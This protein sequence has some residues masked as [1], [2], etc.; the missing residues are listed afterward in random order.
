MNR[1]TIFL[2]LMVGLA[3]CLVAQTQLQRK[4]LSSGA[5]RA[6]SS[7]GQ[8]YGSLGQT[9]VG[10]TKSSAELAKGFW[11]R[12]P[13]ASA[14]VVVPSGE[15]EIGTTITVPVI[16][17]AS[18]NL[19][20]AGALRDVVVTLRYNR[21]VLVSK[22]I[23][24]VRFDGDDAL[25]TIAT[26]VKDTIGII[27]EIP[28]L[29]ALGNAEKTAVHIESVEWPASPFIRTSRTDGE[30]TVLGIC[31]E[32][33]TV[34][35]IKRGSGTGIVG[36]VPMPVTTQ[37]TITFSAGHEGMYKIIVVD[38][39]GRE[40]ATLANQ[41]FAAGRH[42]VDMPASMVPSGQYHVVLLSE[43]ETHSRA[44]VIEK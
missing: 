8:V 12:V 34:R 5:V 35:L 26:Q 24:P 27:A 44:M 29:V 39:F 21:T 43:R 42:T 38:A 37:A 1:V 25:L 18:R 9:I 20:P 36:I 23:Y 31:K 15:G 32:G 4:V 28:C 3:P 33:D 11:Y 40:Y 10:K 2:L 41:T 16:L 6:Q 7:G 17:A 30:I 14:S 22:S 19:L 13:R